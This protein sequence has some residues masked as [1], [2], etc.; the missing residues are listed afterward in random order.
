MQ[1]PV[2]M[3]LARVS[4][5]PSTW[6]AVWPSA[7]EQA[8]PWQSWSLLRWPELARESPLRLLRARAPVT[9]PEPARESPPLW[10]QV[11]AR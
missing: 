9:P 2:S 10:P 4:R 11:L 6:R 3:V 5:L 1:A 8:L 7:P